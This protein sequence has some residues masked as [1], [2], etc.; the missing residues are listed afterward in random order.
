MFA[1]CTEQCRH[2]IAGHGYAGTLG[3]T[4]S[5]TQCQKWSSNTPH[6]VPSKYTDDKFPDGSREA[7]NNYCRNPDP[8]WTE[9]PWCYTVDSDKEWEQCDIP[10]CSESLYIVRRHATLNSVS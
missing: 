10:L 7:A 3:V 2:T 6:T 4:K 8:S 9:G 5:G 1:L